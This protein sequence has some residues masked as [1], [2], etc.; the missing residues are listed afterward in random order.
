MKEITWVTRS[1]SVNPVLS[2]AFK[3]VVLKYGP[4]VGE[5]ELAK[6]MLGVMG[7]DPVDPDA[8]AKRFVF[9]TGTG[10][11]RAGTWTNTLP[12]FAMGNRGSEAVRSFL[13]ACKYYKVATMWDISKAKELM[14]KLRVPDDDVIVCPVEFVDTGGYFKKVGLTVVSKATVNENDKKYGE[15]YGFSKY[16]AMVSEYK[17]FLDGL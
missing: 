8:M 10:D 13:V 17:K 4:E 3:D 11:V 14:Y 16:A 2:N 15:W 6:F 5:S 1:G 12:L 9:D 7:V